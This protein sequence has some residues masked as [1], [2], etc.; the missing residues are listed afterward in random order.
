MQQRAMTAVVK[1]KR[2]VGNIE[3]QE[4][5][6][7]KLEPDSLLVEVKAA[8]IC[9][10]DIH[11]LHDRSV[12][13]PPVILGHEYAGVVIEVGKDVEGFSIED[14]VTSPATVPCGE[15]MM[16]WTGH[17]NRCTSEN[18]RILGVS[19]A[20]GAFAKIMSVPAKIA[21]KI[22]PKVSFEEAALSEPTACV[23]H[24]VAERVE[25]KVGDVVVFL[26]PGPMGLL[27][28]QVAKAQGAEQVI[29]TGTKAD[30]ER[31]QLAENLGADIVISIEEKAVNE[32][33]REITDGM[34]ADIV[35]EAAGADAARRQAFELVRRT[36]KIGL[37]GITGKLTTNIDLDLI[38]EKELDVIGS[39]GTVWTSWRRTLR[40]LASQQIKT[41]PLISARLRLED[42]EQGFK[43]MEDKTAIKVLLLP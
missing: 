7:P 23:V 20:N 9:G 1:T 4:V 28:L 5:E 2:G 37:I 6:I 41:A 42:W 16:C 35:F 15:C 18:K 10:T 17:Q 3:V 40:L 43:M 32:V 30:K 33:V 34:G 12:Y 8:G 31:L 13:D 38:V 24:A 39:W 26:G 25:V 27:G 11:I 29:V 14:R 22:P 36:G 21:H 19:K